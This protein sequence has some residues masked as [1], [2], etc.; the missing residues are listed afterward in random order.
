MSC[1]NHRHTP[2]PGYRLI[3][4]CILL[5][6]GAGPL[7]G[8]GGSGAGGAHAAGTPVIAAADASATSTTTDAA[9]VPLTTDDVQLYLDVMR[10]AAERLRHP[11]AADLAAR[12]L[13]KQ[14]EAKMQQGHPEQVTSAELEAIDTT[15]D[16]QGHADRLVV[17]ERHI[18][19]Q[20]Y[21]RI[22][23]RVED[24][25]VPPQ[26]DFTGDGDPGDGH[27]YV[28]TAHDRAVAAAH[29][30]NVKFLAPHR[31]EI[32]ALQTVVR[33]MQPKS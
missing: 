24:A 13:A 29:D 25:V 18:D 19:N 23:D 28:P 32:R 21:E 27:P 5:A 12:E 15:G 17:A 20:R 4:T 2:N 16:L 10:A 3:A 7:A 33:D 8:C 31:D 1:I 26:F 14:A 22:V 11:P 9:L 30:A 6:A